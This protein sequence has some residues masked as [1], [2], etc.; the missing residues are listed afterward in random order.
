MRSKLLDKCKEIFQIKKIVNFNEYIKEKDPE[1][2]VYKLKKFVL[3]NIYFIAELIKL[4]IFSK[5]IAPVII[6]NLFERYESTKSDQK[7]KL[8]ILQEIVIFT[9]Q[10]GSFIHSKELI[11]DQND[12]KLYKDFIDNIFQ[13]LEKIE[14]E[15]SLPGNIYYSIINLI[16]K[17][18]NNYQMSKYEEYI[19]KSNEKQVENVLDNQ[20]TKENISDII[21]NGLINYKDFIEEEGN[22]D[23]YLW[24]E[25]I[26]LNNV[27]GKE[28]DDILEGYIE[29]CYD[30]I[31]RQS[32]IKYAKSYI[33]DLIEHY[34]SIFQK[35]RDK[36]I[37]KNRLINLFQLV[38]GFAIE[39][40]LIYDIY[41]Y[42]IFIFLEN[43]IMEFRDLEG[44]IKEKDSINIASS[45][46][47]K[48]YKMILNK[49]QKFKLELAEFSNIKENKGLF[50]WIFKQDEKEEE[51]YKNEE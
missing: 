10:F 16:E 31:E 28:F 48:V 4:K 33:K 50:E 39:M 8:I 1:E 2:R 11:M 23:K 44:I 7:L 24:N 26:Y 20:I 9:E 15:S 42:V 21:Y 35:R 32:N 40:P 38:K 6:N 14:D 47:K 19:A 36:I 17:R 25:I 46:F 45:I 22:S 13:K 49:I 37:L 51:E 5:R 3:G 34:D 29:A 43:G 12:A 27:N 18:K 30:F 41:A